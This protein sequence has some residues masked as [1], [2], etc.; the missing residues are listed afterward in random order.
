MREK[1]LQNIVALSALLGIASQPAWA[2]PKGTF[3]AGSCNGGTALF[4]PARGADAIHQI[5]RTNL[6]GSLVNSGNGEAGLEV[7][8]N[9]GLNPSSIAFQS[10][11]IAFA[12]D[13]N[14]RKK[15]NVHFCFR[16]GRGNLIARDKKLSLNNAAPFGDGWFQAIF[17]AQDFGFNP[18]TNGNILVK[19]TVDLDSDHGNI[20]F[21]KTSVGAGLR[22]FGVDNVN[23]N[24]T[25]CSILDNCDDVSTTTN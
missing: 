6:V 12:D 16:D 13:F 9:Y 24:S 5:G 14:V 2:D 19:F 11:S 15:V 20:R 8:V 22:R 21:G 1:V 10:L 4:Q 7:L 25:D 17:Q 23:L 3:R 18:A